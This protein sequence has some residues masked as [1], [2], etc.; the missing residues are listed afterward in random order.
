MFIYDNVHKNS[1]VHVYK[2]NTV[3]AEIVSKIK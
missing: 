2:Y 3:I 1:I